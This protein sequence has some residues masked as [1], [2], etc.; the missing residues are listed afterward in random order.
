MADQKR[1][2][3]DTF[4]I[5]GLCRFVSEAGPI[6]MAWGHCWVRFALWGGLSF[7][8]THI[9]SRFGDGFELTNSSTFG[10]DATG[11][12]ALCSRRLP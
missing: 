7:G 2:R 11:R 1:I 9:A 6:S 8:P 3:G 4:V 10:R 12:D 5:D